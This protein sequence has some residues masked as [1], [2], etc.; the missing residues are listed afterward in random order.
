MSNKNK[1]AS[2]VDGVE[3]NDEVKSIP[4]AD[5]IAASQIDAAI[6]S[7]IEVIQFENVPAEAGKPYSGDV[8]FALKAL[9][10][11]GKAVMVSGILN[12]YSRKGKGN[13]VVF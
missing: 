9:T 6:G 2:P 4:K 1:N 7:A 3:T 13:A 10:G 12:K 8:R 11:D 5:R